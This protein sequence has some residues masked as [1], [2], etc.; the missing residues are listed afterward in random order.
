M[1]DLQLQILKKISEQT[2]CQRYVGKYYPNN[3]IT[4]EKIAPPYDN[5][6][7]AA[8][9]VYTRN[10]Q[11][12]W[13]DEGTKQRGKL[14]QLLQ[15]TYRL[16]YKET[17]TM[18]DFDFKLGLVKNNH[19]TSRYEHIKLTEETKYFFDGRKTAAYH[20][21]EEDLNKVI[22][23]ANHEINCSKK[24]LYQSFEALGINKAMVDEY[25][26]FE[27][28]YGKVTIPTFSF[29][30]RS[31]KE[32]PVFAYRYGKQVK[33]VSPLISGGFRRFI[34]LGR[35][36]SKYIFGL[37]QLKRKK[38]KVEKLF[39]VTNEIDAMILTT[40]G[41]D[42]VCV[43]GGDG[44]LTKGLLK[45]LSFAQKVIFLNSGNEEEDKISKKLKQNFNI[46][47]INYQNLINHGT[48]NAFI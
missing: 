40:N 31:T 8:F 26:L 45:E 2:I 28:N 25:E 18:I 41:Y 37:K 30:I 10:N 16:N 3:I 22:Y 29:Y 36:G 19:K 38:S 39:L 35:K 20:K 15:K 48:T 4:S 7:D 23:W 6:T 12:L 13:Q 5:R 44:I 47:S 1:K 46:S 9:R 11:I 42:T 24:N 34:H 32:N 14:F 33:I 21:L 27:L 17:L 43:C